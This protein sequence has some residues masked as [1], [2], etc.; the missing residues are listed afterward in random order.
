MSHSPHFSVQENYQENMQKV[1]DKMR[2]NEGKV[3]EIE[4]AEWPTWQERIENTVRLA[5]VE[6]GSRDGRSVFVAD[7]KK[8]TITPQ[9]FKLIVAKGGLRGY[10]SH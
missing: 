4:P 8:F 5:G 10:E 2:Q 3:A 7:G 9:N 6:I 1:K